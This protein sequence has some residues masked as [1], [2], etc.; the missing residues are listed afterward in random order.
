MQTIFQFVVVLSSSQSAPRNTRQ[1]G[2]WRLDLYANTIAHERARGAVKRFCQAAADSGSGSSSGKNCSSDTG[3]SR[4]SGLGSSGGTS[5]VMILRALAGSVPTGMS[6]EQVAAT[7]PLWL[8]GKA[9]RERLTAAKRVVAAAAA[10]EIAFTDELQ[11]PP[12][13]AA[14]VAG[15]GLPLPA[16]VAVSRSSSGGSGG[17]GGGRRRAVGL[18]SSQARAITTALG[19]SL[20][21]WQG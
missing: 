16:G 7:P 11:R 1:G 10:A 17:G 15:K 19:R 2:G 21:L 12:A 6:L 5:T 14:T 20:T 4:G 13:P 9:G 3:G 8:R 18:N